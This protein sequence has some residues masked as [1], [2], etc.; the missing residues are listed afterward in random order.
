MKK[1]T[2]TLS[3][4]INTIL[5]DERQV[6]ANEQIYSHKIVVNFNP[7]ATMT[8]GQLVGQL[9]FKFFK[10]VMAMRHS[11]N[12]GFS[13]NNPFHFRI[14]SEG[15]ILCDTL[16][17][18]ED[19]KAKVRM[20]NTIDGQKRFARLMMGM[21]YTAFGEDFQTSNFDD[22][23]NTTY[24]SEDHAKCIRLFADTQLTDII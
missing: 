22:Y 9:N 6:I 10:S 11:G 23:E 4:N 15:H 20:S 1:V 5:S 7:N 18:D 21:L 13:F 16:T 17:L 3:Q 8:F 24:V 2:L 12:K 14:E 19:Q